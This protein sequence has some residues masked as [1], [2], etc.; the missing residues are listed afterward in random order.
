[1]EVDAGNDY[2]VEVD[3][4]GFIPATY[5]SVDIVT[6]ETTI[7]EAILQIP[8][9]FVGDGTVSGTIRDSLS[10]LGVTGVTV[11][12]REG[13]NTQA[14][15]VVT[16]GTTNGAGLFS[17]AGVPTG[18]YTAELAKT[19][20]VTAFISI[21]S[22]GGQTTGNQNASISPVLAA[23][24]TRI[25]LTWGVAPSDLDSHLTGPKTS[26]GRFHI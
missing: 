7:L 14:G 23:G 21:Y 16:T 25:V 15:A 1:M 18:Y 5:N 6:D 19:G 9:T 3:S 20:Y 26:G 2:T 8:D 22:L 4:A 24:E 12:L 11:S 10:A 17:I 13:L